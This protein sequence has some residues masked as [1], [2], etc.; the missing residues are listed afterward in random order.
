MT[1]LDRPNDARGIRATRRFGAAAAI[2]LLGERIMTVP[3]ATFD[4]RSGP[5]LKAPD[6]SS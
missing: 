5:S 6:A 4:A 3:R 2:Q 1:A